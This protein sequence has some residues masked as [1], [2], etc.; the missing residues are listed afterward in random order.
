MPEMYRIMSAMKNRTNIGSNRS[1]KV[2]SARLGLRAKMAKC[3][4]K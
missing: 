3:N 2:L 4:P 1:F